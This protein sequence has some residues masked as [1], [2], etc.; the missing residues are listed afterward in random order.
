MY[1]IFYSGVNIHG[2]CHWKQSFKDVQHLLS[3]GINA[4]EMRVR[5][6]Q[7][8]PIPAPDSADRDGHRWPSLEVTLS[9]N[10]YI[11]QW[12]DAACEI[13]NTSAQSVLKIL[14]K[15]VFLRGA[16]RFSKPTRAQNSVMRLMGFC[17]QM[18]I[19]H[20]H[21]SAYHPQTGGQMKSV[22]LMKTRMTGKRNYHT[23]FSLTEQLSTN[24][25]NAFCFHWSLDARLGSPQNC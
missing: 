16:D 3:S 1:F 4:H 22:S 15:C 17:H 9:C 23:R 25:L 14:T 19:G 10:R 8:R 20:R 7:L 13:P 5:G 24:A 12:V 2:R 21:S 6:K 18:G 11:T